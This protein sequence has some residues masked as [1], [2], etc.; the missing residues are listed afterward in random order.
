MEN[1]I[2]RLV[3][4]NVL[5]NMSNLKHG[6]S[7]KVGV[8]FIYLTIDKLEKT[9]QVRVAIAHEGFRLSVK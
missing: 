6:R 7:H 1:T 8:K 5:A 4:R 3:A 9:R 2:S